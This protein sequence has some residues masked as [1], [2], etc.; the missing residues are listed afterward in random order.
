M[1]ARPHG[2]LL[3]LAAASWR[4]VACLGL[5]W[6]GLARLG[7]ACRGVLSL[8]PRSNKFEFNER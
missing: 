1:M 6:L 4:A 7:S 8:R 3:Q 2:E 5:A